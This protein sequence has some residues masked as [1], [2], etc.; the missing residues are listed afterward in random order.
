[1]T[2]HWKLIDQKI[3]ATMMPEDYILQIIPRGI[4]YKPA[5]LPLL[6]SLLNLQGLVEQQRFVYPHLKPTPDVYHVSAVGGVQYIATLKKPFPHIPLVASQGVTI[7]LVGEYIA[8]GASSVVLSNAIFDKEAMAQRNFIAV[9]GN[10]VEIQALSEMYNRPIHI[11]SYTTEGGLQAKGIFRITGE[12]DQEK[13]VR[14]QLNIGFMPAGVDVPFFAGLI[15]VDTAAFPQLRV[16]TS[17]K[18]NLSKDEK[19]SIILSPGLRRTLEIGRLQKVQGPSAISVKDEMA[20]LSRH[21]GSLPL[22]AKHR[23][24]GIRTAIKRIWLRTC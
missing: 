20:R 14:K 21:L 24:N 18:E 1:M 2:A 4:P 19:E 11:Y 6:P 7:G 22:Q 23:I 8:H 13:D 16:N 5:P 3:E 12:N 10:N 9:Y 17:L 15:K